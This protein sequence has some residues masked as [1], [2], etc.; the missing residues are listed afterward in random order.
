MKVDLPNLWCIYDLGDH[1]RQ[2]IDEDQ[3]QVRFVY[4]KG[5]DLMAKK[6]EGR[7]TA[8]EMNPIRYGRRLE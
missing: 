2:G 7:E 6:Q 5:N 3:K 8:N 1:Y 4:E